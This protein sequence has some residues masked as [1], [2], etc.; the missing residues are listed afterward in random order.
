MNAPSPVRVAAAPLS[1]LAL[2]LPIDTLAEEPES[3]RRRE[4]LYVGGSLGRIASWSDYNLPPGTTVT[5]ESSSG[6]GAALFAGLKFD[7]YSGIEIAYLNIGS[8]GVDTTGAGRTVNGVG[9]LDFGALSF[10]GF[11]PL[12]ERWELSARVG[13]AL[14]ASYRTGET[15]RNGARTRAGSTGR[16]YP[17]T[18]NSW[19]IGGGARF[20]VTE[21][22]GAR[23]DW[24]YVNYQNSREGLNYKPHFFA[25]GVDYR[26]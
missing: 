16:S 20:A 26:F 10:V 8:I 24:L 3:S 19:L 25:V 14:D 11:L 6:M 17:C 21:H 18:R 1:L 15:C 7:K 2:F 23:M 12:G 4:T 9:S 22:W 5:R 13:A